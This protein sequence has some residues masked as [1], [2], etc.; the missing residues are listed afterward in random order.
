MVT[1]KNLLRG[2]NN[3]Q[4]S[5]FLRFLT[6]ADVICVQQIN[7]EFVKRH[8]KGRRPS[9]HTCGPVLE[10]PSTYVNYPDFRA[11]WESILSD[12]DCMLMDMA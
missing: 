3:E 12:K 11:E 4:I 2:C 9:A 1:Y 6:A 10:L 5:Y 8:G 7:V